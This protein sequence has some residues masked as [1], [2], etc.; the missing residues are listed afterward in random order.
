MGFSQKF[1]FIFF[2]VL[3]IPACKTTAP[4]KSKQKNTILF[5]RHSNSVVKDADRYFEQG[6]YKTAL[7]KYAGIVYAKDSDK[8]EV[9][10]SRYMLG[11]C[12]YFLEQYSEA[13]KTLDVLVKMH[14]DFSYIDKAKEIMEKS[15]AQIDQR[16]QL[17]AQKRMELKSDIQHLEKRVSENPK[18]GDLYYNLGNLYWSAGRFRESVAMYEKAARINPRYL[19]NSHIQ[20]RVR[21]TPDGNFAV[22]DPLLALK[23]EDP[24]RVNADMERVQKANWLG[25]EEKLR[26]SGTVENRGLWDVQNVRIEVTIYDFHDVVQGTKLVPVGNLKAGKERNFS[27]LFD[28]YSG[29]AIDI[30]KFTTQVFYEEY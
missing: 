26:V 4:S 23:E 18:N 20:N 10:H 14:P 25:E 8:E 13:Y 5:E 24:V 21:I 29:M 11:L 3:L 12:H 17:L 27:V 30:R 6:Q 22:R 7:L 15:K 1:F 19:E 9:P 2:L 16:N 28:E